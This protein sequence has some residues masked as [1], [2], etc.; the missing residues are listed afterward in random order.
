M[1]IVC[2]ARY[3]PQNVELEYRLRPFVPDFI[4]AVGDIDAFLRVSRPD[5]QAESVGLQLLDEPC[6]NQSEPAVLQLQLRSVA[7]QSSDKTVV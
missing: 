7:K 2:S 4:P 3:T 1:L 5:G 6:A